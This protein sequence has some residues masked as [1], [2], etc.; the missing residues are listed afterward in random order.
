MNSNELYELYYKEENLVK[1]FDTVFKRLNLN[2]RIISQLEE[3][4]H[5]LKEKCG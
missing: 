3:E 1:V 5:Q 2:E 4:I